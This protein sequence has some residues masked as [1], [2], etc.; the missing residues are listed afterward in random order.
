M[1]APASATSLMLPHGH[2]R[3]APRQHPLRQ[4]MGQSG[5]LVTLDTAE[6]GLPHL[7]GLGFSGSVGPGGLRSPA[8]PNPGA[9]HV[10][11]APGFS[12]IGVRTISRAQGGSA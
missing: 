10:G 5:V 9:A 8:T 1:N 4:E 6:P 12:L 2:R 3:A 11:Q 7:I